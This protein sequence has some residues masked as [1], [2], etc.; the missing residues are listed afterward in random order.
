VRDVELVDEDLHFVPQ[1]GAVEEFVANK[2]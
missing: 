2:R 1:V